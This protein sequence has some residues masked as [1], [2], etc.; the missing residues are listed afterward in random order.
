[1]YQSL[2]WYATL[3]F[4]FLIALAFSFVYGESR[5]LK[6]YGPIQEKGYK[7]RK[8]YFLG[9]IAIMG[10]ASAVSLSR[11]PYHDQ[12]A[13][14]E[15]QGKVVNV[16]GMQ[17]S[18]NLSDETFMVG[19]P[20]QF[21]VT[22]KDVTHGFGLYDTNLHLMAQTQAMP[23][24]INTVSITFTKPGTYKILCLEYCS[25]GHHLMMKDIIVKPNGGISHGN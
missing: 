14:A 22:S 3:F 16:T 2:A 19:E 15:G 6:E 21:R 9:L 12:H 5:K 24:Y 8:F 25:T 11:L 20:V 7:I 23:G 18:W 17:F 13:M 1:M 10:F 4:V